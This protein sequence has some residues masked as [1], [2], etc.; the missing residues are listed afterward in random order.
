[1]AHYAFLNSLNE[2]TEVITGRDEDEVVQGISDWESYYG[3]ERNQV[4]KRTSYST[5]GGVHLNGGAPFR[6]NYAGVGYKY[7]EQRDAFIPP[8][9]FDSWTLNEDTCLWDSPVPYPTDGK[10]YFWF[11]PNQEW[12]EVN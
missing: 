4:C 9:P 12:I 2:V 11:E 7:D 1:M 10:H 3:N 8:K 6:K 5:K